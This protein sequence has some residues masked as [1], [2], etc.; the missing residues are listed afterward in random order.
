MPQSISIKEAMDTLGGKLVTGRALADTER[1]LGGLGL[2]GFP[3]TAGFAGHWAAL[4]A[5]AV[6]D[7]RPAMAIVVASVGAMLG[8]V[9]LARLMFGAHDSRTLAQESVLSASVAVSALIVTL[10]VATTPQLLN[11]FITRTLAAFS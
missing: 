4:Q 5:L 7:W 10:A 8:F 6:V 1:G 3:L 2:V 11:D 9:R